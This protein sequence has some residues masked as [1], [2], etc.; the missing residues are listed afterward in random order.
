[1]DRESAEADRVVVDFDGTL[2]GEAIEGGE[3]REVPVVLGQGKMLPDF[4]QGLTGVKAD[5][6]K[7]F[8]VKFPKDYH[9]E[10][11]ANKKVD[12]SVKVHRVEEEAAG[13][14]R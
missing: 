10:E 12:F 6:E 5:E 3:G 2:K 7:T 4:E 8:K 13:R 1:V 11:L 9:V 14:C